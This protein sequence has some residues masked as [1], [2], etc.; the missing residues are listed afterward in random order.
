M[1][2]ILARRIAAGVLCMGLIVSFTPSA[3]RIAAV[4]GHIIVPAGRAD[5]L[6]GVTGEPTGSAAVLAS[7]GPLLLKKTAGEGVTAALAA[8]PFAPR[9]EEAP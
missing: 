7:G 4:P 9:W 8:A 5:A 6:S 3:R 1:K 2:H